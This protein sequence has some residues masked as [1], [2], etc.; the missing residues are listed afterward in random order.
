MAYRKGQTGDTAIHDALRDYCIRVIQFVSNSVMDPHLY[1]EKKLTG[2]VTV[3]GSTEELLDILNG[4]IQLM[5]E[6]QGDLS[7][8]DQALGRDGLPAL[9]LLCAPE[10]RSVGLVLA[11]SQIQTLVEYRLVG[12][13]VRN[14]ST[15]DADRH[16]AERL[17]ADYEQI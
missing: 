14:T 4:L 11:C 9:S 2:D 10:T 12:E 15:P 5:D 6:T 7:T 8:I 13:F 1:F 17:L 3:T 16:V